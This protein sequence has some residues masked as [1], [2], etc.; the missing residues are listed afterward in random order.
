VC[1]C[2]CVCVCVYII[3]AVTEEKYDLYGIP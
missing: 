3:Y 2:V 1:V